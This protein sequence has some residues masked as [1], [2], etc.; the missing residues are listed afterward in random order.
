MKTVVKRTGS[1]KSFD[2]SK[3]YY[4]VRGE[5]PPLVFCYGIGCLIN[6]WQH[7]IRHFSNDYQTIVFDY[8][9]HHKSEIPRDPTLMSVTSI[10]E[11]IKHLMDHLQLQ[12]AVFVGHSFGVQVLVRTFDLYPSLFQKLVFV[13]GFASN[14]IKG[15]FGNDFASSIFKWVKNGYLMLPET[16]TF[17]W[18]LSVNNPLAIQLSSILGGFNISLTHFKDIEIYARG[19]ASMDLDSFIRLFESMMNYDGRD[20][21]T[22]ITCPTLIIGGKKDSVTPPSYQE[23]MYNKI[24]NSSILM[25][26]YGSHCTQ[27]DMPDFV[28]LRIETFLKE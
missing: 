11:D 5:G 8:R 12:S 10:A 17:L 1:F 21:L 19:V 28:N 26:P 15:M 18:K 22:N 24:P 20:I 7:Q 4:E 25:V 14:P 13:N 16:S 6:H 23:E 27:L 3:I 2:G 9:G